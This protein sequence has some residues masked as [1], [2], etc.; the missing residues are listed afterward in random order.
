MR[1]VAEEQDLVD[2]Q[3]IIDGGQGVLRQVRAQLQATDLGPDATANRADVEA[4]DGGDMSVGTHVGSPWAMG[5][6][7]PG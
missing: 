3:G 6:I 2:V 7:R 1:L 4:G 5:R